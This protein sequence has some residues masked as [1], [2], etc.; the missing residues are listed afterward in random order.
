MSQF[1]GA[2][3][4]PSPFAKREGGNPFSTRHVRPGALEYL[5]GNEHGA[6]EL[7][8]RLRQNAWL[9]EI[10][11]PHGSGKSTLLATLAP[12]FQQAG[13]QVVHISLHDGQRRLPVSIAQSRTWNE[14]TQV[15]V[16][17]YEQ[18][19][20]WSRHWL[21]LTR[22]RRGAGLLV[23]THASVGLPLLV[24][25]SPSLPSMQAIVARL[26]PMG[27]V[28]ITPDDVARCYEQHRG[29]ARELLFALYDLYELR[30]R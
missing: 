28:L 13:R 24:S 3:P 5:F 23:T 25:T 10:V 2:A 20:W 30:R 12:G 19:G 16:D 6:A 22:R 17:G 15:V 7:H 4:H 9:G 14:A 1:E 11:G 26:L 18:L 8:E 27:C 29:N 21:D